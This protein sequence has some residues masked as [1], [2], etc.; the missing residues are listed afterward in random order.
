MGLPTN[1]GVGG[2]FEEDSDGAIVGDFLDDGLWTQ[3][4]GV[5]RPEQDLGAGLD[6]GVDTQGHDLPMSGWQGEALRGLG[7]M[8]FTTSGELIG[9]GRS[10]GDRQGAHVVPRESW[11]KG[12]R[13]IRG[14]HG[15]F[16][17]LD[18]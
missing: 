18:P 3:L 12:S 14:A 15:H 5:I 6:G 9:A 8:D 4:R 11:G 13:L 1:V 17:A 16:L 2:I 7:E 10:R